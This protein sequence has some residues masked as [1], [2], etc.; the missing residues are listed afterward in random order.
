M[1]IQCNIEAFG[2]DFIQIDDSGDLADW[3]IQ[4]GDLAADNQLHSAVIIQLFTDVRVADGVELPDDSIVR[5]GW[6]GDDFAPFEIG[7][8]L[9]ILRRSALTEQTA[10]DAKQY[11]E[12]ALFPLLEQGAA[13][14]ME[15][16]TLADPAQQFL[17]INIALYSRDGDLVVN[18]KFRRWWGSSE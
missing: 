11:V 3:Q 8:R 2:W 13:V 12:E 4:D 9:W 6:W 16:E 18:F 5:G 1:A 14:R 10:I 17:F 7:S 15:V